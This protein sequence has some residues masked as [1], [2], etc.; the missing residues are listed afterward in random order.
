LPGTGAVAV[1]AMLVRWHAAK[2]GYRC[3]GCGREFMISAWADL[4]SPHMLT[5]KYVK[6]PECGQRA[7]I[8]ALMRP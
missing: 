2:T 7:W 8:E 5:T 3:P 6:C 1:L 4:P